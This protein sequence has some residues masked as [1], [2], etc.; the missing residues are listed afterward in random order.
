MI[1][2]IITCILLI[3]VSPSQGLIES[4]KQVLP[5]AEHRQCARHIYANFR[6]RFS[7]VLF[8]NL[9]WKISKSSY[10]TLFEENM[11]E[12]KKANID[13]YNYL[14]QRDPSSWC[15]AF[16]STN[17]ACEAVENGISECFNSLIRELRRKPILTMLE[18]IRVI[19]MERLESMR[20]KHAKWTDELCPNIRKRLEKAKD[21]QR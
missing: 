18:A 1:V 4:V 16:F 20:N 5:S 3:C 15:R 6:K 8:R 19:L 7:G 12:L 17:A 11:D 2:I 13:A 14:K 9:F 21:E 10:P